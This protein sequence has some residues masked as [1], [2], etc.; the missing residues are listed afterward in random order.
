MSRGGGG[1]KEFCFS[2]QIIEFHGFL[3]ILIFEDFL[4]LGFNEITTR[5]GDCLVVGWG[6]G[7]K[8]NHFPH[9]HHEI[10]SWSLGD[11]LF[12]FIDFKTFSPRD[13]EIVSW[14]GGGKEFCVLTSNYLVPWISFNF[15][16]QRFSKL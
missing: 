1:G 7:K 11:K 9:R 6:Q 14:W 10:I 12:S 8:K 4:N 15:N 13:Q 2:L 5:P 3:L 16:F